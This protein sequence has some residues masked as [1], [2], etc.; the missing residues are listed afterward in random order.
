MAEASR[1][2]LRAPA[3]RD[4]GIVVVNDA[5]L[6]PLD[7]F[8]VFAAGHPLPDARGAAAAVEVTRYV[9]GAGE[10][11]GLL[12]LVSGGGSAILPAPAEGI[13]LG[14]K[15]VTTELLLR[16]GAAIQEVNTVRKHLSRLKGGGLARCASPARV[17]V[18]IV[19]DVIGDDLSSIA[20]G[21]TAPDPT[22]FADAVAVLR[23]FDI[24]ERVPPAVRRRL[25]R[26]AAGDLADTPKEGDPVFARITHHILASNRQSLD[27]ARE[28]LSALGYD[29]RIVGDALTGEARDAARELVAEAGRVPRGRSAGP[30]A[31]LW[32]G[33]TTVTVRG[34]GRGGR[35]QELALAF[36]VEAKRSP[37]LAE[38]W[39]FL[40]AGT[41]GID[42]PTDAAGAVV[43]GGTIDKTRAAGLD[44]LV[45]LER[46]DAYPFLESTGALLRTGGTGT[47]VAD[48]QVYLAGG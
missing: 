18:L 17:E 10:R 36:A 22:T 46:N 35:N 44:P 37:A 41:D 7:G 27:A 1:P 2:A 8:R 13:S 32:G 48:L 28:N 25:E 5:N 31:L 11:D 4:D 34:K 14:E 9:S 45:A 6:R 42:G 19:S 23:R 33:E 39:V 26:G 16:S 40:S 20:S 12:V 47:N 29:A 38:P 30:I 21:P 43:D 3:Y 15:I 24:I